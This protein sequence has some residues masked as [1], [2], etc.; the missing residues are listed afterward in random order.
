MT[1]MT[2]KDYALIGASAMLGLSLVLTAGVAQADDPVK[3][4]PE[5][6]ISMEEIATKME[7]KYDGKVTEIE[8]DREWGG[9]VYEIE[10]RGK[11]GYEYDV[12]VDANSG[13]IV[14]EE[15]EREDW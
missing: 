6:S 8:L 9:D 14:K 5:P 3:D 12:E 13:E 1:H 2:K 4:R 7:Q 10:I 11:D 15:R